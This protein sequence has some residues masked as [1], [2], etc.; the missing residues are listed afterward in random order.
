[1]QEPQ[2]QQIATGAGNRV[3][4]SKFTAAGCYSK[5]EAA[6][7]KVLVVVSITPSS[8]CKRIFF[9]FFSDG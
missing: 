2:Q 9:L 5:D 4:K 7:A 1:V 8:S 6:K 3:M